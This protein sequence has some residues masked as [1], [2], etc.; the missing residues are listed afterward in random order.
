M[1]GT[2]SFP[3]LS[4][5]TN[6]INFLNRSSQINKDYLFETLSRSILCLD[7][8][9]NSKFMQS[10]IELAQVE[11]TGSCLVLCPEQGNEKV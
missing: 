2:I 4:I 10:N 1:D 7:S 6:S 5:R 11:I 8:M 9:I 3:V